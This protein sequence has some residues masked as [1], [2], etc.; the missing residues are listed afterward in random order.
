MGN[1]FEKENSCAGLVV[2]NIDRLVKGKSYDVYLVT[3]DKISK[4]LHLTKIHSNL[5]YY[6]LNEEYAMF[7]R[8]P[9]RSGNM[10]TLN[11]NKHVFFKSS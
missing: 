1:I 2:E 11:L 10:V 6:D 3:Q 5:E 4:L 8:Q 9:I 7:Y